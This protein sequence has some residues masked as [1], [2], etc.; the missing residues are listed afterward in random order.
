MLL[1]KACI[2]KG[3][4]MNFSLAK[5]KH[6]IIDARI[7]SSQIEHGF[8]APNSGHSSA[9]ASSCMILTL[10]S[11]YKETAT[12]RKIHGGCEDRY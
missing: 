7:H 9:H 8:F 5:N 6:T 11:N 1:A 4:T 3:R 2:F 12:I 10:A